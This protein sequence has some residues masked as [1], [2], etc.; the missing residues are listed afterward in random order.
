MKKRKTIEKRRSPHTEKRHELEPYQQRAAFLEDIIIYGQSAIKTASS[1][2]FDEFKKN[3]VIRKA[4]LY[5]LLSVGEAIKVIDNLEPSLLERYPQVQW[6]NLVGIRDIAAHKYFE[7]DR[8]LTWD[9][10]QRYLSPAIEAAMLE[11]E[12]LLPVLP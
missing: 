1:V 5:D 2:N 11:L 9:T 6:N 3:D 4:I 12:R 8:G 7:I 10:V